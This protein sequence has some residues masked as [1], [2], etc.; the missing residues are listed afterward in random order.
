MQNYASTEDLIFVYIQ[1]VNESLMTAAGFKADVVDYDAMGKKLDFFRESEVACTGDGC[2]EL[3]CLTITSDPRLSCAFYDI[4]DAAR[5]EAWLSFAKTTFVM[6][7]LTWA[8][9]VFSQDALTLVVEPI[10]RMVRIR[11]CR[12]AVIPL[13]LTL[14]QSVDPFTPQMTLVQKLAENPLGD[15]KKKGEDDL[16]VY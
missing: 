1:N 11:C 4:E 6:L 16:F 15:L 5:I 12:R 7:V 14:L 10:E 13:S 9:Y 8:I 2:N 3:N